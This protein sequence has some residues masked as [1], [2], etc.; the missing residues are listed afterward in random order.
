M[1]SI[2]AVIVGFLLTGL[3]GNRLV[4][5]WQQRN[6]LLQQRFLG[7]EK[8]YIA[9]K[10]L[11]DEIATLLGARIYH[12][13][14]LTLSLRRSPVQ[15]AS[16]VI[17]HDDIVKR[18]NERL[19]SFY[20]RLPLL[21]DGYLAIR[22]E[23]TIQNPLSEFGARIEQLVQKRLA[24]KDVN[25]SAIADLMK[26]LNGVQGR[27]I[28]FNKKMLTVVEN[29]RAEVYYGSEIEFSENNLEQF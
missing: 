19:T 20:A 18:W 27:A 11:A 15:I 24:G 21:A 2:V 22:L 17:D 3:I 7:H 4:Q 9:L 6:W 28:K 26:D 14:R 5:A 25:G 10:E 8:E 13:Q 23:S 12:M 1:A 29:R 16:R